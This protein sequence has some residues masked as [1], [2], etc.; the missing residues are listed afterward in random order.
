MA[1]TTSYYHYDGLGSTRHLTDSGGNV[2]DTYMYDAWGES[3]LGPGP[4]QNP[5]RWVG[6]IGYY[7]DTD[8][9]TYYVR[10]RVFNQAVGQW[11]SQDPLV[12]DTGSR[13]LADTD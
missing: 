11:L 12:R 6:Q 4:T 2:T 10:A 7:Y 1:W 3:L 8:A 13:R 5:F 9:E